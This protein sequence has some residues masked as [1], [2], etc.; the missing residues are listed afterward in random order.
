M[1]KWLYVGVVPSLCLIGMMLAAHLGIWY[2][3]QTYEANYRIECANLIDIQSGGIESYLGSTE[4]ILTSLL[5]AVQQTP[6]IRILNTKIEGVMETIQRLDPDK[7]IFAVKLAPFGSI[8]CVW[9]FI[10]DHISS[11]NANAFFQPAYREFMLTIHRAPANSI[12][13]VGPLD[14]LTIDGTSTGFALSM[15]TYIEGNAN[16]TW[17]MD[18]VS[19]VPYA[20]GK[21][22]FKGGVAIGDPIDCLI[23]NVS[24]PMYDPNV[25]GEEICG[26]RTVN[27]ITKVYWGTI[28]LTIKAAAIENLLD[29]LNAY[30]YQYCVLRKP[31]D[32]TL[33]GD[34]QT[35]ASP[36]CGRVFGRSG[37]QWQICATPDDGW[38]P[39]W[40]LPL[41]ICMSIA[42]VGV[43]ILVYLVLSTS[44]A[45][46]IT[47]SQLASTTK[48]LEVERERLSAMLVR[49][50][51]LLKCFGKGDLDSFMETTSSCERSNL[52]SKNMTI[53][54]TLGT[55]TF[56]KVY[57][58][59][60]N[61]INVALKCL[62]VPFSINRSKHME[63]MTWMEIAISSALTHKNLVKMHTYFVEKTGNGYKLQLVLEY[64]NDGNIIGNKSKD[65]VSICTD[66]VNGMIHLHSYDILHSDL[67][68]T[69]VLMHL[70]KNTGV[71][72]VKVADFGLSDTLDN[73]KSHISQAFHGTMTHMAPEVLMDGRHSMAS[74][75]YA[76]GITMWELYTGAKP[77]ASVPRVVLTHAV[78]FDNKRPVFPI[79]TPVAYKELA[80]DCWQSSAAL[81]P[82]FADVLTR[83]QTMDLSVIYTSDGNISVQHKVSS[84][85]N[86]EIC[87]DDLV[88]TLDDS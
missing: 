50:L 31:D 41:R 7:T 51:A 28:T 73:N 62:H 61:G 12:T 44:Y 6:D 34:C 26:P 83:L 3:A 16:A 37:V 82:S 77:Y 40:L 8:S 33:F 23:G 15:L 70:D 53:H 79:G 2:G 22:C 46:R 88:L 69:N 56:A 17:G 18:T 48:D 52:E 5:T 67:K 9:P 85:S 57:R 76:F 55:G 21:Q 81:R 4:G 84:S 25:C 38:H 36:V 45:N 72:T 86:D 49:Q 47:I 54:E 78:V 24:N 39:V 66:I 27:N 29:R 64:C 65:H 58:A 35:L 68:A 80:E 75:V 30:G 14:L 10:P 11:L 59:T 19:G 43:T 20:P 32:T 74:D 42:A 87:C 71:R 60:W 63:R 1:H 13:F